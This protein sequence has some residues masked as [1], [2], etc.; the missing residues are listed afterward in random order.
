MK[1]E[2]LGKEDHTF[3][4]VRKLQVPTTVTKLRLFLGRCKVFRRLVIGIVRIKLPFSIR[5]HNS[6]AI[7]LGSFTNKK[8]E[9]LKTIKKKLIFPPLLSLPKSN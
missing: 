9:S 2:N 7:E 6:Q 1:A 8:L 4:A 5:L 3:D